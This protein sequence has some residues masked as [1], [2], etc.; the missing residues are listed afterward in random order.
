MPMQG[1]LLA[2]LEIHWSVLDEIDRW[3]LSDR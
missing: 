3:T 2:S 1:F